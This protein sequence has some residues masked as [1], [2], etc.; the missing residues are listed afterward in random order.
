MVPRSTRHP[1]AHKIPTVP[2]YVE[3]S[4]DR[5]HS[6]R[7]PYDQDIEAVRRL[8]TNKHSRC[9]IISWIYF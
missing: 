4:P 8:K 9:P 6:R 2:G 7:T 5:P 1:T 3:Q